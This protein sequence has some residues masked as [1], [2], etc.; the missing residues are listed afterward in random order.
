MTTFYKGEIA[1]E[2]FN[3][4]FSTFLRRNSLG[5]YDE[6]NQISR[7]TFDVDWYRDVRDYSSFETAIDAIGSDN[8][9]LLISKP[10]VLTRS[11]IVV[12]SNISLRVIPGY[13]LLDNGNNINLTINGNIFDSKQKIFDFNG[14]GSLTFGKNVQRSNVLWATGDPDGSTNNST[15]FQRIITASAGIK[16]LIPKTINN[17]RIKNITIPSNSILIGSGRPILKLVDSSGNNDHMLKNTD[18]VNIIIRDLE[19][20]GNESNQTNTP[21]VIYFDNVTGFKIIDCYMYDAEGSATLGGFYFK[22]SSEGYVERCKVEGVSQALR[23]E[24]IYMDGCNNITVDRCHVKNFDLSGIGSTNA[25]GA[26]SDIKIT[27][28]FL[29]ESPTGAS[30]ITLN[31]TD[32]LVANNIIKGVNQA[33]QRSGIVCGHTGIPA[34]RSRIIGNIIDDCPVGVKVAVGIDIT[35]MGNY[36]EDCGIGIRVNNTTA[37]GAKVIG[38]DIVDSDDN[39]TIGS[40]IDGYGIRVEGDDTSNRILDVVVSGNRIKDTEAAAISVKWATGIVVSA[41]VG[42]QVDYSEDSSDSIIAKNIISGPT[43]PYARTSGGTVIDVV[44]I[45]NYID[46]AIKSSYI[47]KFWHGSAK[48]VSGELSVWSKGDA[49]R[50]TNVDAGDPLFWVYDTDGSSSIANWRPASQ[51]GYRSNAGT[52]STVLTP[53]YIMEIVFDS[54]G[55]DFYIATGLT[56]TDWKQITV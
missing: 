40:P 14:S 7:F 48:P 53:K 8:V 47:H 35:V 5:G 17:Y 19:L 41:S 13:Y 36:I 21:T 11:N 45:D 52:P 32:S 33:I 29:D 4:G 20:D 34:D 2:D 1:E 10:C 50:M 22:N 30:A 46:K 25:S 12:P 51:V 9:E 39:A 3:L 56:N 44:F 38:N 28:N 37:H 49:K 31:S 16:T 43:T 18:G 27:N 24:G 54:S 55:E 23:P 6:L 26:C 15:E 42:I